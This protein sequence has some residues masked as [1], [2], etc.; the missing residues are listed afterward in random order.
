MPSSAP[1]PN[2]DLERAAV[3]RSA[4]DFVV[5]LSD[6]RSTL[7]GIAWR[8]DLVVAPAERLSVG[9]EIRISGAAGDSAAQVVALDLA[10]D[11]GVVRAAR[12]W[13]REAQATA[14]AQ[15]GAT[16]ALVAREG[17]DLAIEWR[18]VRK[19]GAAWRSRRGGR[20]DRRIEV[21]TGLTLP[22]EGS[23]LVAADGG[24]LGM[25]VHGTRRRVLAIPFE[26]IERIVAEVTVHG[27][28]RHA[29]L[30]VSLVPLPLSSEVSARWH[31]EAKAALVV[32]DVSPGSP[33]AAVGLD[34]GD[35]L[36]AAD[37]APLQGVGGL[38]ALIRDRGPGAV[39]RLERR[40]GA[41]IDEVRVPLGE[42]PAL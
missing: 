21:D 7:S 4:G 28:L 34:V 27:R 9:D 19:I 2:F 5:S 32:A 10:T 38:T 36:L 40:R 6:A 1:S 22:A 26:T 18:S 12:V 31:T 33:A 24:V 13:T 8:A 39:L 11:V 37:G 42:R 17:A 23:A 25:A 20:I 3:A 29:Y 16:A 30:G 41:A 15:S 35:L 14:D